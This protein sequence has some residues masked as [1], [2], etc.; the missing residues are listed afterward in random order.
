MK[1]GIVVF[2]T[3]QMLNQFLWYYCTYGKNVEWHAYSLPNTNGEKNQIIESCKK[4]GIFKEISEITDT[5]NDL[6]VSKKNILLINMIFCSVFRLKYK[7]CK[8]TLE[9][10]FSDLSFDIAVINNDF[11]LISGMLTQFSKKKEIVILEDGTADYYERKW[12]N[13]FHYNFITQ[14]Y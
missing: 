6:S 1:K 11:N 12:T 9:N 13:I 8:K 5:F 2:V 10:Y 4:L 3:P 7:F 14:I